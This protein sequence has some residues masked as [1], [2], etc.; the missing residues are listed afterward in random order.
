MSVEDHFVPPLAGSSDEAFSLR[1]QLKRE[2]A[3]LHQ[4]LEARLGLLE[5]PLSIHRYRQVLEKFYGFYA[6]VEIRLARLAAAGPQIGFPLRARAGLIESDLVAL[7]LSERELTELPWCAELPRLSCPEHLAGCLYVLEG[8]CLGGQV[9]ARALQ[10]QLGVA[11]G[12]GASFF[13]GDADGTA[14]RWLLVVT[15][16]EGLVRVGDRTEQIVASARE[17]FLTLARWLELQGASR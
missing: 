11:K 15:W 14:A 12:S 1:R 8:A 3:T 13:V 2:T 7:G 4:R 10:R 6:P 16:L 17:T 5:P 9:V